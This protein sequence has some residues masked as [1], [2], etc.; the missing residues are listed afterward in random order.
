MEMI[1]EEIYTVNREFASNFNE[2]DEAN[3]DLSN[4]FGVTR[5]SVVFLDGRL[6]VHNFTPAAAEIFGLIAT[7]RGRPMTDVTHQLD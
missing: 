2:L 3:S 5:I 1:N 6:I 7:D 4:P